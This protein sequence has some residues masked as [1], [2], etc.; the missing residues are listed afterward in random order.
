MLMNPMRAVVKSV[1]SGD[2]LILRGRPKG[3]APPPER[4]I[5]LE[6]VM[7]PRLAS[8]RKDPAQESQP[9]AFESREFLRRLLVGKEI[10]FVVHHTTPSGREYGSVKVNG[11]D[12]VEL[13]VA[14]GW[15]S[16]REDGRYS[17]AELEVVENL[18][19]FQNDAKLEE[20]GIWAKD[21]KPVTIIS[22]YLEEPRAFLNQHKGQKLPAIIEQVR[23]ASTLK[24]LLE[25]PEAE[26][27][28]FQAAIVCISGIKA[29]TVRKGVS[30]VEDLVEPFAEEA[31]FYVESRLLQRDIHVLL[32]GLSNHQLSGT[33]LYPAGNIAEWLV[34]NGL[35]KVVD[36][37]LS[38]V[39]GGPTKLRAAEKS[40]KEKKLRIW[41]NHRHT[42]T[43]AK[44]SSFDGIVTRIATGDTIHVKSKATRLE[45]KIQFSSIRAPKLKDPKEGPYAHEAKEFL[46]KLLIGKEVSVKLDYLK[47]PSDGFEERQCATVAFESKDV[48]EVLVKKGLALVIR[49]RKED[50]N[51]ASN[52]DN[53]LIAEDGARAANV[54][55]HSDK[56]PPLHR[57]TD[58][59]ENVAKARQ[60][61]PFLQRS[62]RLN[63]VVDHVFNASRFKLTVPSQNCKL[64]FLL[65]GLRAPKLA[66][67]P[68]ENSEPF[69]EEAYN[70]VVGL[71]MQRD[72]T[73][74]VESTDKTGGFIG[75]LWIS[76]KLSLNC[77]LL[78]E[79]FATA[80][81]YSATNSALAA[82][83]YASERIA[84]NMN[85][86]IWTT[87][88]EESEGDAAALDNAE[89]PQAEHVRVVISDMQD[90][91]R[92]S[93]QILNGELEEL[94]RL[95]SELRI[96]SASPSSR[97]LIPRVGLVCSAQFSA[98][99]QWYRARVRRLIGSQSA[100]VLYLDYGNSETLPLSR[101]RPLP[102][103][104]TK[105]RPQ[106]LEARFAYLR[107]P[108]LEEDYGPEAFE[109]L[110]PLLEGKPFEASIE[111]RSQGVAH[112]VLF[113]DPKL[114]LAKSI[115]AQLVRAGY[116]VLLSPKRLPHALKSQN[117]PLK[118]LSDLQAQA[119]KARLGMWEY[120]EMAIDDDL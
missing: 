1:I 4:Q 62:G 118:V 6:F 91:S 20:K 85:R 65:G 117:Q 46:R 103:K 101:L 3:N 102:E 38:Q 83:L 16:V 114:H 86:R 15:C 21:A 52:Y 70:Y 78:E 49:H 77:K 41:K 97:D 113:T 26:T 112:V 27:K 88:K 19:S 50:D 30:G 95:M 25:L 74:E 82:Q 120:G 111:L 31:K 56:D 2:T 81:E 17:E 5:S 40:A 71:V 73:I 7:A 93:L 23:D 14:A 106:A 11:E 64:T 53:L 55:V 99:Q 100:E 45:K 87:I 58:A 63:A 98:D 44:E 13:C 37:S 39:T 29:P 48:G 28:T 90:A 10:Q 59:S 51:R 89:P 66:R 60:F 76:S 22:Q 47:P 107:T 92:F 105:L 79:G 24:V 43:G 109:W 54:G 57:I 9:F 34:S 108:T 32:E 67:S 116:G 119:K 80:H 94:D 61:L 8:L 110:K 84:K 35:A 115:N 75:T 69:G 68:Q 33:I 18:K 96:H 12:V 104:F 36:W 72:V 42:T